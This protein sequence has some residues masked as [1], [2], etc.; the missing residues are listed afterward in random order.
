MDNVFNDIVV[1]DVARYVVY[2]VVDDVVV[3]VVVVD[4]DNDNLGKL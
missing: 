3:G 2:D 1:D 4:D